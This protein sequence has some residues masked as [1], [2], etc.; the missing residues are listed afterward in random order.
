M[1]KKKKVAI[2]EELVYTYDCITD[3]GVYRLLDGSNEDDTV[4]EYLVAFGSRNQ[5]EVAQ[6]YL[7]VL[8]REEGPP[9]IYGM[10]YES[11]LSH[12]DA[13]YLKCPHLTFSGMVIMKQGSS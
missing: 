1:A 7:F 8:M 11:V 6:F 12:R 13:T 10:D 9:S 3:P 2:D 5:T 4:G